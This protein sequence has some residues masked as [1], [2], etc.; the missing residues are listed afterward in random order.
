MHK[1]CEE[2]KPD[3]KVSHTRYNEEIKAM[4]FGFVKLGEEECELC[5]RQDVHLKEDQN[6]RN[7]IKD[8]LTKKV[9]KLFF[10]GCN[11]CSRYEIHIHFANESRLAY[12]TDKNHPWETNEVIVSGDL[13]K[14]TM[15]P[16]MPGLKKAIFA[17]RI[18]LFN[19]TFAPVGGQKNGKAVGVLWHEWKK[20]GRCC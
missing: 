4:N 10:Q 6:D 2:S 17:K 7:K 18:V 13:M 1:D 20:R 8:P 19:E 5:D 15:C 9:E 11:K 14:V 16:E 12:R 3:L